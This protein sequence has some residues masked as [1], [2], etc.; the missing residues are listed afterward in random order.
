V[1]VAT[2]NIGMG[3]GSEG[4]LAAR[5]AAGNDPGLQA[6]AAILHRVRPD[7][8]LLN[9]FD[10][11]AGVEAAALLQRNYLDAAA[12][13][14]EAG[15]PLAYPYHFSAPVNTGV[16]SGLDLDNDGELHGPGDAWGYGRFPGQYGMLLLSRYPLDTGQV[17]SFQTFRWADMPG[18]LRPELPDGT[19]FHPDEVW[20]Q[21]RLSS[22]SH[23]DVPVTL[24]G[25]ETLHLLA[26]HPTPPVFD[27]P[28]DR[29]GRRNHDEIRLWVDYLTP[30]QGEYLRDDQGGTGGLAPGAHWVILGDLNADPVDGDSI[31][32]P[33]QALLSP[34]LANSACTP[35]SAGAVEAHVA[36]AGINN[37]HRGDPAFDTSDFNDRYTGNLRVDYAIASNTLAVSDCGV[38]W[39]ASGQPGHA[40]VAFSDHRL[41]WV[42]IAYFN[43]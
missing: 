5:L 35:A 39:P 27:G 30:G 3:L 38:H 20:A 43:E 19:P 9:E 37:E 11:Q 32:G 36:Q 21:L 29:N 17:R 12:H 26:S 2:F 22:K 31:R 15:A 42:D 6:L 16:D 24:P 7:V 13:A 10:F 8:V 40:E 41:V 25:G 23:W 18:A 4:E 14:A 28:E 1:R 33:V 34:A